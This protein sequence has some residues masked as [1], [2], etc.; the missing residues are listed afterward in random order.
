MDGKLLIIGST[1]VDVVIPLERLPV[2]GEDLQS[3]KQTFT[4]GG[5]GWN[6]CRA[7]MLTGVK[8][9]FLSPVGGGPYGQQ[10][11]AAFARRGLEI[12]ARPKGENGCC[13]C[14]VEADGE[15]T[16]LCVRGAEYEIRTEWLDSLQDSYGLCCINGMELQ[17]SPTGDNIL[18]WLERHRE[19]PV[20]Y[21]PGPRGVLME[22]ARQDRVMALKPIIHLNRQEALTLSGAEEPAAA[23]LALHRQTG[24][25]VFVTLGP[26]GCICADRHGGLLQI[27]GVP[28][29]VA[30]TIGAGDTHAGVVL[31]CLYQG[32]DLKTAIQLANRVAAEVVSR[33]GADIPETLDQ[34]GG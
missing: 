3:E 26:D 34:F 19:I 29:T 12:L 31:G 15:R 8:P 9:V 33:V 28:T 11:E 27:P 25:L 16:F 17:D 18:D 24:N 10:V 1:C 5:T 21:A 13:Y 20:F 6:V 32:K 23:A 2:T 14:L 7:A 30:D 22:A 4:V